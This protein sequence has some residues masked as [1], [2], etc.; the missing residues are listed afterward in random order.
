MENNAI[1]LSKAKEKF[2]EYY[3]ILDENIVLKKRDILQKNS[4]KIFYRDNLYF[5]KY[6]FTYF[7]R[8]K[9]IL[10]HAYSQSSGNVYQQSEEPY[11]P[12]Y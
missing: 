1:L 7:H 2:T 3:E 8:L 11:I 4:K 5:K 9:S 12:V 10:G 6:Y